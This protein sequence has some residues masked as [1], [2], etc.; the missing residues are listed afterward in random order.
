MQISFLKRSLADDTRSLHY[1]ALRPV[2]AERKMLHRSII[3][4]RYRVRFPLESALIF[5]G[6]RLRTQEVNEFMTFRGIKPNDCFGEGSI[7]VEQLLPRFAVCP[8][9][10]MD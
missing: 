5:K 2:I 4:K 3:P 6:I 1:P 7:H 8:H 9:Y 10:G